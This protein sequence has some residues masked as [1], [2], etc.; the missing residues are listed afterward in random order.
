LQSDVLAKN[1]FL[2]AGDVVFDDNFFDLLPR[3]WKV[4]KVSKPV[5]QIDIKTLFDVMK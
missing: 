1:V 3:A 5:Q 4:I 2:K